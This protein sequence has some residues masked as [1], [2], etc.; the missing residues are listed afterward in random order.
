LKDLAN[1]TKKLKSMNRHSI[2]QPEN[3]DNSGTKYIPAQPNNDEDDDDDQIEVIEIPVKIIEIPDS[4]VSAHEGDAEEEEA[5]M[6]A[7]QL[8]PNT[9]L[10][11]QIDMKSVCS[12]DGGESQ[13]PD[14][15]RGIVGLE[16]KNSTVLV[17][18]KYQS[19]LEFF[20]R[21]G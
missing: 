6:G 18:K 16:Q 12:D 19:P 2:K 14:D 11:E 7:G 10:L 17:S 20:N 13:S 8:S 1:E 15:W 21:K 9:T 4:P 3:V 5:R